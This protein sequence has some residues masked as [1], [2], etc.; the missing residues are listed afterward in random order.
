MREFRKAWPAAGQLPP[1]DGGIYRHLYIDI[2]PRRLQAQSAHEPERSLALSPASFASE[3][4]ARLPPGWDRLL[5]GSARPIIYL[6]F[7][8]VFNQGPAFGVATRALA[9]LDVTLVVTTGAAADPQRLG[10]LPSSVL[11]HEF[12]DQQALLPLCSAVVSHGGAGTMLGAAAHGLPQL[13]L[14]QAADQFR[15][16]QALALTGAGA[17][18]TPEQCTEAAVAAGA[19]AMLNGESMRQAA[20]E[21]ADDISRMPGASDV[22]SALVGW[23]A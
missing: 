19:E 7:G 11:V 21:L 1:D 9:R 15:N 18:L 5:A 22:V 16:A 4:A 10:S 6:S 14:P 3:G 2:V 8:T 13:L 20:R 17:A 12:V 23:C